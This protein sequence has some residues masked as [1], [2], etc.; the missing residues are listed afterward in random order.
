MSD[1]INIR[2]AYALGCGKMDGKGWWKKSNVPVII[3]DLLNKRPGDYYDAVLVTELRFHE[4][5]DFAYLLM[6]ECYK[7][8]KHK[9]AHIQLSRNGEMEYAF[10]GNK[11]KPDQPSVAEALEISV[12]C[13]EVLEGR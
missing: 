8:G 5:Y 13:L 10:S 9:E 11:E 2:S 4:S 3:F 1:D 12:A 7:R 6:K